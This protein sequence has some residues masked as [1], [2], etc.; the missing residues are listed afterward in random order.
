MVIMFV[1][2]KE[3]FQTWPMRAVIPSEIRID[4]TARMIGMPAATSAPKTKTRMT[5]AARIPIDS[6]LTMSSSA[7]AL[8]S[9][10]MLTYP[11]EM[12]SIPSPLKAST[13][14]T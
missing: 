4:T 12:T 13:S 7:M 9:S 11:T 10:P 1:T 8:F 14:S 2:K 6:P 3:R 5:R